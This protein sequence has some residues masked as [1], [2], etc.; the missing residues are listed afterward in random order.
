MGEI[1]ESGRMHIVGQ[2]YKARQRH[3]D[4]TLYFY[5][6][7]RKK[8][9]LSYVLT[10]DLNAIIFS[11]I[12]PQGFFTD[13]ILAYQSPIKIAFSSIKF[14]SD[15]IF[16][17]FLIINIPTTRAKTRVIFP[18]ARTWLVHVDVMWFYFYKSCRHSVWN[19]FRVREIYKTVKYNRSDILN[20]F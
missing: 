2:W 8:E 15:F 13:V 19:G 1:K 14:L 17:R 12:C 9:C 3:M 11:S 16:C 4:S 18:E 7:N 6:K 20:R 5:L 10:S